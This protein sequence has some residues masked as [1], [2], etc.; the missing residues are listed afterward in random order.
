MI[1]SDAQVFFEPADSR[2]IEKN[3]FFRAVH[4]VRRHAEQFD[5]P[6]IHDTRQLACLLGVRYPSLFRTLRHLDWYYEKLVIPK[7]N[8]GERVL[9]APSFHL[10]DIQQTILHKIL[11]KIP[12][13]PYATAYIP[14][15]RLRANA[16]PHTGHAYLL[17]MDVTDFF[18]SIT[19]L[20]VLS[21]A[22]PSKMYPQHIGTI[23]TK[24]CCLN[25]RLPQGAPT[26]PTLSNIVMRR[27]DNALG[28]W[29]EQRG[30]TYTRYCD[31]LTFSADVPLFTAYNKAKEMLEKMGLEVNE[32][33]TRFIG[34]AN[35]QTVTGLTVNEKVSVPADYKRMLRQELHYAI[36]FGIS[37]SILRGN[38]TDFISN[39]KPDAA[40]YYHHLKGKTNFVLSVEPNNTWFREALQQLKEVYHWTVEEYDG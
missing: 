26:S 11:Y 31:D 28:G 25:D 21:S 22:F 40:R 39:G 2:F 12:V 32:E 13:S 27:F 4:M 6:F 35:R 1:I 18:G 10:K 36:R 24:L 9:Y 29:C 37:D 23:L 38:K 14:K 20:Q 33:K 17:K 30:I 5:T 8:G 16:S 19:F 7:K 15:K 3:G 34:H